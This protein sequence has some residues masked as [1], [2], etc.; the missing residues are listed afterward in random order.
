VR[1]YRELY[2]NSRVFR[3]N[4]ISRRKDPGG[5]GTIEVIGGFFMGRIK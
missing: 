4:T 2:P 3:V 1:N 5:S